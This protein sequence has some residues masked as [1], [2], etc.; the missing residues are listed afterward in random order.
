M[1]SRSGHAT[2]A[3]LCMSVALA[4]GVFAVVVH[5]TLLAFDGRA[6]AATDRAADAVGRV[7]A[8]RANA[9][10]ASN[11]AAAE[12][13]AHAALT[14]GDCPAVAAGYSLETIPPKL[15]WALARGQQVCGQES[16]GAISA[17]YE[18]LAD[19]LLE[20]A[21]ELYE[22][23]DVDVLVAARAAAEAQGPFEAGV[24]CDGACLPATI[25][26]TEAICAYARDVLSELQSETV[27]HEARGSSEGAYVYGVF[28]SRSGAAL[29][30]YCA[31][32]GPVVVVD[33]EGARRL[34]AWVSGPEPDLPLPMVEV[35]T[36]PVFSTAASGLAVGH[37]GDGGP[38]EQ[39]FWSRLC[40][41]ALVD[42]TT[43]ALAPN[44]PWD[45]LT[46]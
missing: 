26:P 44:L 22:Q 40:P 21:Y 46:H 42:D 3:L 36:G 19:D 33:I 14:R 34:V 27:F 2:V 12:A 20:K 25:E 29:E 17:I 7:V 10:A 16:A 31:E 37:D 9:I 13:L 6:Q 35:E 41:L 8:N 24:G 39:S 15:A 38:H 5:A 32:A 30:G 43:L 11:T 1:R 45:D 4:L 18:Q 28:R 23:L